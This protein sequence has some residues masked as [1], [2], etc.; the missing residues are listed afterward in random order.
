MTAEEVGAIADEIA[1]DTRRYRAR[2][3]FAE[4][5]GALKSLLS[6]EESIRGRVA[7]LHRQADDLGTTVAAA[8]DAKRRLENLEI[9]FAEKEAAL[10]KQARASAEEIVRE[11]WAKAETIA[12]DAKQKSDEAVRV[13]DE[14]LRRR[15]SD[16]AALDR[17][18]A[19]REAR[20]LN[21]NGQIEKLRAKIND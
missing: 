12:L 20:L 19:E 13:A 14:D 15:Q 17:S 5:L 3:A 18:I 7:D 10:F 9:A 21:I 6:E 1:H 2:F 4:R 8:D 11:A 16:I